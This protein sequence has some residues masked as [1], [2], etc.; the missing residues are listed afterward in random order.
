MHCVEAPTSRACGWIASM[1]A[2]PE[3]GL[4]LL[5][6]R[7]ASRKPAAA[8]PLHHVAAQRRHVAQLGTGREFQRIRDH[9]ITAQD[10]QVGGDVETSLRARRASG[11]RWLDRRLAR[12]ALRERIDVH[13]GGRAASHP[14]SSGRSA[15]CRRR[16]AVRWPASADRCPRLQRAEHLHGE[17]RVGRP[18][19]RK[20]AHAPSLSRSRARPA[21]RPRRCWDRRRSGRCCRL[22]YSRMSAVVAGMPSLTQ[23]TA[24]MIWPGVQ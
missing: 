12:P 9:G 4:R 1:A 23:A 13:D 5:P 8:C 2:Q 18:L 14:A 20:R 21:S 17:R 19:I 22:I 3:P 24:D 15:W 7:L 16:A 10:I 6:S 11:R